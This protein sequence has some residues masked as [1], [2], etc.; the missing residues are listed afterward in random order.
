MTDAE[1]ALMPDADTVWLTPLPDL[2][3]G[4]ERVGL[5]VRWQEDCSRSH[6]E[7]ADALID[8][9]EALLDGR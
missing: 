2:V 1:R 5:R 7:V 4:L 3:A 9:V 8:R 6:Q